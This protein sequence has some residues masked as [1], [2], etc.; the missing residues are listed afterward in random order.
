LENWAKKTGFQFSLEKSICTIF[1]EKRN[2]DTLKITIDKTKVTHRNSEKMLGVI[3]D[4]RL[5]WSPYI[6]VLKT[7]SG[8]SIKILKFLS[9]TTWSGETNALIKI[10]KVLIQSKLNKGSSLYRITSKS[11]QNWLDSINNY[12]LETGIKSF[13]Q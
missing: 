7:S 11:L 13:S 9:H 12:G 4:K 3:F 8:N 10:H 1:T 5:S 6:K 2:I